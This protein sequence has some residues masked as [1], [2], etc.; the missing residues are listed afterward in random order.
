VIWEPCAGGGQLARVLRR[1]GSK[2]IESDLIRRGR[3][4]Q[5]LW[6]PSF[7]WRPPS[8]PIRLIASPFIRHA[9]SLGVGYLALLLKADFL[10]AQE[11]HELIRERF[12]RR[13]ATLQAEVE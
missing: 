10:N 3:N 1:Y 7:R 9:V 4:R 12:A 6:K 13:V 2:V 8:S 11:R 5:R